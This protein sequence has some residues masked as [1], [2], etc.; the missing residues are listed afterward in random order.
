MIVKNYRLPKDLKPS[1]Y[2]IDI[3]PYFNSTTKPEYFEGKV[4]ID[5]ECLKDTSVLVLHMNNLELNN[6]TLVI[7]STDSNYVSP[8]N[9]V[10]TYDTETHFF[11]AT[12]PNSQSFKANNK[13][14]FSVEFKGYL[15]DDNLG[16]YRTSYTDKNDQQKYYI[17][18]TFLK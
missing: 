4:T 9:F 15:K 14:S 10:Y 12:F 3:K 11:T 6:S 2:L 16:F 1:N 5:F 17:M 18:N 13:Y 7:T 8:K